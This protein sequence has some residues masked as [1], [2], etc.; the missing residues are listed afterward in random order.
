MTDNH[1]QDVACPNF[2]KAGLDW[3]LCTCSEELHRIVLKL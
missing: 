3:L 2:P 1:N